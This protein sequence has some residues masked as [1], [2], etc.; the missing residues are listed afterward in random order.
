MIRKDQDSLTELLRLGLVVL[1][2]VAGSRARGA[3]AGGPHSLRHPLLP[4][5]SQESQE[6]DQGRLFVSV[7]IG[8]GVAL[9][10]VLVIMTVA[11]VCVR[12]RCCSKPPCP[13]PPLPHHPR[14]S[15]VGV[16]GAGV[17]ASGV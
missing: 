7:I 9:L 17:W 1:V 15:R 13:D 11:L 12:K 8:L 6:E 14:R 4:Q 3:G 10:L 16:K 2:S 5:G